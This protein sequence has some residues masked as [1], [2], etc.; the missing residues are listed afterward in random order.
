MTQCQARTTSRINWKHGAGSQ[1]TREARWADPKG[2]VYCAQHAK[3]IPTVLRKGTGKIRA[4]M[5]PIGE[6][7]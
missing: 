6:A 5:K 3:D 7:P 2:N 1:C 4:D